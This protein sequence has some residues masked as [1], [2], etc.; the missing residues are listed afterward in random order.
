MKII[1]ALVFLFPLP[2]TSPF[3]LDDSAYSI[4]LSYDIPLASAQTQHSP[5][6]LSTTAIIHDD[7]SKKLW[8]PISVKAVTIA[9]ST[10]AL[11]GSHENAVTILNITNPSMPYITS[12]IPI[13]SPINIETLAI[14]DTTY[15]IISSWDNHTIHILN[16]TDPANLDTVAVFTDLSSRSVG[17]GP[18]LS[19]GE[20]VKINSK[21]YYIISI[22]GENTVQIINITDPANPSSVSA[23]HR[24]STFPGIRAPS[25]MNTITIDN[26]H[27]AIVASAL[28]NGIQIINITDPT[29]MDAVGACCYEQLHGINVQGVLKVV[30]INGHLYAVKKQNFLGS[31]GIINI[32]DL[33]NPQDLQQ[34][35]RHMYPGGIEVLKVLNSTYVLVSSAASSQITILDVTDPSNIVIEKIVHPSK[36]QTSSYYSSSYFGSYSYGTSGVAVDNMDIITIGPKTF[37]ISVDGKNHRVNIISLLDIQPPVIHITGSTNIT[38][39]TNGDLIVGTSVTDNNPAYSAM[40]SSNI[41]NVNFSKPGTYII[42][43]T[44][45]ADASGNVP[46]PVILTLVIDSA[47]II[48]LIGPQYITIPHFSTFVDPG[49]TVTDNDPSYTGTVSSNASSKLAEY[50]GIQIIVYTAP[51]DALGNV[52]ENITRIVNVQDDELPNAPITITHLDAFNRNN[53]TD[54]YVT[55]NEYVRINIVLNDTIISYMDQNILNMSTVTTVDVYRENDIISN[56]I[57][58]DLQIPS[59]GIEKNLTFGIKVYDH[60]GKKLEITHDDITT[61]RRIFV[62]TIPPNITLNGKNNTIAIAGYD[63]TDPGAT[64]KDASFGTKNIRATTPLDTSML[65]IQTLEYTTSDMAGNTALAI[66]RTVTVK[67][68]IHTLTIYSDNIYSDQYATIGDTVTAT[69]TANTNVE[70]FAKSSNLFGNPPSNII[71]Q[72]NTVSISATI[73]AKDLDT[74]NAQFGLAISSLD[75]SGQPPILFT[76]DDLTSLPLWIDTTAP[77]I[78]LNGSERIDLILGTPYV[79]YG[80]TVFDVA[81]GTINAMPSGTVNTELIGTYHITYTAPPDFAGNIPQDKIRTVNVIPTYCG[82]IESEY[83][84]IRGTTSSDILTGTEGNDLIF[85]NDGNDEIN[86]LGGSD[87]IYGGNGKDILYGGAGN[88]TIYGGNDGDTM[89]G[90]DGYD[91]MYGES[92]DDEMYGGDQNDVMHGGDDYDT[93]NGD[94]GD[95]LMYGDDGNDNMTGDRGNDEMHGNDGDDTMHGGDQNDIM[96]GG[97]GYDTM[98]G[99]VGN[100]QMHG[101]DGN[102]NMT[103][104]RGTDE[105]HG[106]LGDDEMSG[107]D[108]KDVMHGGKGTDIMRGDSGNDKMYGGKG[109]DTM[110]GNDGNDKIKGNRGNDN[111]HGGDG[112]DQIYGNEDTNT[113]TGGTGNDSCTISSSDTTDS[114]ETE[115]NSAP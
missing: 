71:A 47:P 68:L 19:D 98:H 58:M 92:G 75:L 31:I 25:G 53:A 35:I 72:D 9:N 16:I 44:A 93:M 37:A 10:Y 24:S 100:D 30:E 48:E 107:G 33:E 23:V 114:C 106:D 91:E 87:C 73:T 110:H 69:L 18:D 27:Y 83:N 11:V 40:V 113:I 65:G 42:E 49:A 46:T 39:P 6:F 67:P 7:D 28:S 56:A 77:L 14:E 78:T 2:F 76:Q 103:G 94:L 89:Y 80:A 63:Y 108:D 64:A 54:S 26:S 55:A 13:S 20:I 84:V 96:H 36:Y 22:I 79:E 66:K 115:V 88:D 60:T 61:D 45:P 99:N 43:Y 1:I 82:H 86:G 4:S 112:N 57:T 51:P 70:Y 109:D 21:I 74:E 90:N 5:F 29:N 97:N 17:F 81:Y 52:P 8:Q 3:A 32:T 62:D 15:A 34:D 95:D 12:T 38:I 105:M 85:G 104:D 102:D 101:D 41:S 50:I 111:L 59:I